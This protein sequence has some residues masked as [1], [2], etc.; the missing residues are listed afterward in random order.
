M[1][2]IKSNVVLQ[3]VSVRADR[4]ERLYSIFLQH[5]HYFGLYYCNGSALIT[6][7]S[8]DMRL[9]RKI[10]LIHQL[11]IWTHCLSLCPLHLRT[12]LLCLL[13]G[14]GYIFLRITNLTC[15]KATTSTRCYTQIWQTATSS[16]KQRALNVDWLRH[17]TMAKHWPLSAFE[18]YLERKYDDILNI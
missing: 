14:L 7:I 6:G 16:W 11:F 13:S 8:F 9:T 3:K 5:F 4:R 1:E 2:D 17:E 10:G 18:N 12:I 15:H